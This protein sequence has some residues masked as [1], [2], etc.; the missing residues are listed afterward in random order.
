M[1]DV[2][3]YFKFLFHDWLVCMFLNLMHISRIFA[4]KFE[5]NLTCVP[6]SID[7]AS[8]FNFS[9]MTISLSV[10]ECLMVIGSL[11]IQSSRVFLK[12][13]DSWTFPW[14]LKQKVWKLGAIHIIS[15]STLG[16]TISLIRVHLYHIYCFRRI[17]SLYFS[18]PLSIPI[19]Y[20]YIYIYIPIRLYV[21]IW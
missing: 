1:E 7:L 9:A 6:F 17:L 2:F 13:T 19:I 8:L 16:I 14:W 3:Y 12:N 4:Y 11:I 15:T 5:W 20:I 10:I 18:V 21:I